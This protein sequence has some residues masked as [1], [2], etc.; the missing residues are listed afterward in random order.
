MIQPAF[1]LMGSLVDEV[2]PLDRE[3]VEQTKDLLCERP[4][5]S[6]RNAVH[7]AVMHRHGIDRIMSF[8]RGFDAVPG[9]ERVS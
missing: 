4:S 7:A 1:D 3:T 5:L 9:I 6:D 8:D 2:L